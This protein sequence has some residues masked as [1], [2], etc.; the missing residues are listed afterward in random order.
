M[1]SPESGSGIRQ[2][3]GGCGVT[4]GLLAERC[5][6]CKALMPVGETALAD[7]I[8][9][10][11]RE[12]SQEL[13]TVP[14]AGTT[15]RRIY[16]FDTRKWFWGSLVLGVIVGVVMM[17]TMLR[18]KPVSAKQAT[19]DQYCVET[20]AREGTSDDL[21]ALSLCRARCFDPGVER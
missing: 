4:T 2:R 6:R 16:G 11:V 20:A 13:L 17:G 1:S 3:C 8:K 15:A 12:S 10:A 7:Q 9:R 14:S 21:G 5:P 18:S 19:C